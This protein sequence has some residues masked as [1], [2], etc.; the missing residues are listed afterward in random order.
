MSTNGAI[1]ES[2]YPYTSQTGVTGTCMSNLPSAVFTNISGYESIGAN[3]DDA[4]EAA[5]A[6]GP[7]SIGVD[8]VNGWQT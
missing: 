2:Q 7:V 5:V 3:S 4:L 6:V 8:A 1:L